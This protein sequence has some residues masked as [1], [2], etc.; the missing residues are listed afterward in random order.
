MITICSSSRKEIYVTAFALIKG[1]LLVRI[2]CLCHNKRSSR[3]SDV[4]NVSVDSQYAKTVP[5]PTGNFDVRGPGIPSSENGRIPS[6]VGRKIH[7]FSES[8]PTSENPGIRKS[9]LKVVRGETMI[10]AAKAPALFD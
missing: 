10:L 6:L 2:P 8:K 3:G 5:G 9:P 7:S 1:N 4:I